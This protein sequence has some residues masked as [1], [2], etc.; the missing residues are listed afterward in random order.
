MVTRR[1]TDIILLDCN[2][3]EDDDIKNKPTDN[4]E[5]WLLFNALLFNDLTASARSKQSVALQPNKLLNFAFAPL[6]I[7]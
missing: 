3:W 4:I 7:S 5:S 6:T 1:D 2:V